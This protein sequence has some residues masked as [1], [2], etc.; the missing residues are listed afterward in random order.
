MH[1]KEEVADEVSGEDQYESFLPLCKAIEKGD[2]NIVTKFL[3]AHPDAINKKIALG[4]LTAL[5]LATISGKVNIAEELINL[6]SIEG[7]EILDDDGNTA[8]C[9][10]AGTGS[11]RIVDLL[12]TKNNK[13]VTIPVSVSLPVKIACQKGFKELTWFLYSKTP[14]ELLLPANGT[15]GAELLRASFFSKMFDFSLDLIQRCPRLAVT[16]TIHKTTPLIELSNMPELF[17]SSNRLSFWKLRIYSGIQVQ[18]PVFPTDV[19][20]TIEQN[21]KMNQGNILLRV[22]AGLQSLGSSVKDIFGLKQIYDLKLTHIYALQ[23]IR[24]IFEG[25]SI[26]KHQDIIEKGIDEALFTATEKGIVEIVIEIL[27]A[28]PSIITTPNIKLRGIIACAIEYRQEKVFSIIYAVGKWKGLLIN[29][30]DE[31]RNSSLHMAGMLAP[32]HR[33][34]HISSPA[35]QMQRELQWYKEVESIVDPALKQYVNKE[36]YNPSQLFTKSHKELKEEG[37]KWMK[38]IATSS[39]VVGALIIT[40]MFTTAFTVPG[41]NFQDTGFPIFLHKKAFKVFIVADAISLFASST[42]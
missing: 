3:E 38:G 2:L 31:D 33:L 32:A 18:L 11:M 21:D 22:F 19:R 4:G 40:I 24:C 20:I 16:R 23:V 34:A 17:P 37:E 12:L 36:K 6:M 35:L 25:N 13:L 5:H 29:S 10:A 26:T 27:K 41:G 28:N 30:P 39:T 42:S 1:E 9:F 15:L 8:L 7:L 14:F